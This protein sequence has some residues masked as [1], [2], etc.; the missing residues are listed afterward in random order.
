MLRPLTDRI[1]I[2]PDPTGDTITASGVLLVEHWK[3]ENLGEVVAVPVRAEVHCP[4][5]GSRVFA[6]PCVSVGDLVLF[7]HQSGQDITIDGERYLL[8]REDDLL[9]VYEGQP[10]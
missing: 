9:A 6:K 4:E 8:M 3:P 1:L 2:K 5:C 10:A 7:S